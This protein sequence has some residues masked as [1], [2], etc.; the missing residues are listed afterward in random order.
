MEGGWREGGRD[1]GG[2]EKSRIERRWKK[3][4]EV[5]RIEIGTRKNGGE[6]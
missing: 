3:G 5:G 1:G 4:M 6:R 2:K